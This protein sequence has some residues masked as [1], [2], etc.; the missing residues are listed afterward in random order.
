MTD[1]VFFLPED[2]HRYDDIIGLP[3]HVSEDRP[4]MS[5]YDRAAQFSPFAA[6][7]GYDA[8][9]NEAAR[10][11]EKRPVLDDEKKAALDSKIN[12]LMDNMPCE[13][14]IVCF[15][16]DTRKS[17]GTLVTLRGVVRTFDEYEKKLV[18][19]DERRIPAND[20]IDIE[21]FL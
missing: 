1:D 6:L 12:E 21:L 14:E 3:H 17:G 15:V 5:N 13:A 8:S 11:T 19:S 20:I 2:E 18:F 7:T 4:H 10:L 9:V 16:P